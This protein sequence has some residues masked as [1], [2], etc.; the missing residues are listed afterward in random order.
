MKYV[1]ALGRTIPCGIIGLVA[2]GY[3][4]S[5][6]LAVGMVS[7]DSKPELHDLLSAAVAGVPL[8]AVA[9][10][11]AAPVTLLVGCPLYALLLQRG[12]A[13]VISSL[14]LVLAIAMVFLVAASPAVALLVGLYGVPIA[15]VTHIAQ[16]VRSNYSFKPTPSARLN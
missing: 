3:L 6:F 16:R 5:V 12:H 10:P 9:L 1:A 8:F 11:F 2:G 4:A 13:S 14:V 15:I 7:A